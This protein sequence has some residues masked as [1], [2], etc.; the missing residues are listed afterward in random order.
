[1]DHEEVEPQTGITRRDALR[2]GAL[3]GG[4]LTWSVPVVQLVGMRPAMAQTASPSCDATFCSNIVFDGAFFASAI[5]EPETP[6]DEI[7]LCCCAG[8]TEFCGEGACIDVVNACDA[9]VQCGDFDMVLT[10]GE[11]GF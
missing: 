5:C 10:C 1:M 6:A 2:R 7:C 3:L 9:E 11:R 8:I 4:A